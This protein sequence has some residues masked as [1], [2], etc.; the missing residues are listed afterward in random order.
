MNPKSKIQNRKLVGLLAIVVALTVCGARAE[1]QQPKTHRIG[2]LRAGSLPDPFL[3]A[4][5]QGMRDLGYIEGK[6]ILIEYRYAEGKSDRLQNLAEELVRLKSDV[7]VT[8]DTPPIR[9]AKNA[10][11]E[12]PIIM[13]NVADPVAAGLVASLSRP[14]S[15]ITGL[16]TLAPEL[17]GKRLELLKETLPTVTRVAWIWDP[18]NPAL[19]IRLKEMQAASQALGLKLQPLEVRNPEELESA[20]TVLQNSHVAVAVPISLSFVSEAHDNQARSCYQSTA[21][22]FSLSWGRGLG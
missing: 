15:N 18:G 6:N 8:A 11:T 16:S 13:G 21:D 1:G 4:F 22:C 2:V 12:I 10:T 20:G 9:A 17:D 19:V 7:I 14:G 3:E 5:R